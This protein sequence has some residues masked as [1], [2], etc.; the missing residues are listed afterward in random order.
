MIVPF[1]NGW[2]KV[3]AL[4]LAPVIAIL[5]LNNPSV[6]AQAPV[7]TEP[8]RVTT[9]NASGAIVG[10]NSFK[11]I[12]PQSTNNRGRAGCTIQNV[13]TNPMYVYFGTLASATT[14]TS[15]RL[16]ANQFVSCNQ[17]GITLQD[18]VSIAGTSGE[19]YYAAQQ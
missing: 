6:Q 5:F 9:T 4:L 7:Y 3:A 16:L 13:G 1:G 15:V 8:Y 17:S 12:W 18:E 10:T 2:A 14:P 19:F 11:Q